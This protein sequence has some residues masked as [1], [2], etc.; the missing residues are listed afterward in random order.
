MPYVLRRLGLAV[1]TV[2]LVMVVLA[3]MTSI[4]PGEPARVILGPRASPALIERVREEMH[5]DEPIPVQIWIFAT[6]ALRGDL[7]KDFVNGIPVRDLIANALSGTVALAVAS[8]ALG[9]VFGVGL[10][11]L[12]AARAGSLF[13]R[14]A[15]VFSITLLSVPSYVIG[16]LLVLLLS[17]TYQW[18]PASGAGSMQDPADWL[19]RLVMPTLALAAALGG[20]LARL[21][22]AS[23][24]DVLASEHIRAARALGLRNRTIWYRYALRNAI[25]PIIAYLGVG[26]GWV[27]SGAVVVELI[28]NR[29]GLGRLMVDAVGSRNYTIVRGCTLVIAIMVIAANLL[30]DLMLRL[31]DPRIDLHGSGRS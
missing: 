21:T 22:R 13:D 15:G 17:V 5:L 2:L 1:V 26:V 29:P 16:L 14:A 20:Y 28:F 12:S 7:G 6:G 19:S 9:V 23:M 11:V 10:G 18:L 27:L 25:T 30:A 4:V 3:A 24:L 31:N 8:M